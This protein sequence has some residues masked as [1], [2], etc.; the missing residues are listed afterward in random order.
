VNKVEV[1]VPTKRPFLVLTIGDE[2]TNTTTIVK[3]L[4]ASNIEEVVTALREALA[5]VGYAQGSISD[6]FG[7][8]V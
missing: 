1:I 7:D 2:F 5:G 8:D 3:T 6:V 4:Y